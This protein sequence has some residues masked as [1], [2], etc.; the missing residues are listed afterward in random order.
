MSSF[1]LTLFQWQIVTVQSRSLTVNLSN[2]NG[3]RGTRNLGTLTIHA[4]ETVASRSLVE[5][6]FRCS[7]LENK[8]L[9]S[10][11]V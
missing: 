6:K 11:S 3:R 4:E 7:N 2:N 1:L 8:D 9:F 10:K 5:I